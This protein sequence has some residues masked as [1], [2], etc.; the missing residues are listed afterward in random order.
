MTNS[1][2][3]IHMLAV[4]L[5]VTGCSYVPEW[6]G[7]RKD[8][9]PALPGERLSV[10]P[11]ESSIE[12]DATLKDVPVTLPSP[13]MNES[14][15]QHGGYLT[16]ASSNLVLAGD[17][18]HEERAEAGEGE[19]FEHSLIPRPI[20]AQDMVFAMDAEGK[21]SAHDVHDISVVRWQSD[22]VSE[23]DEPQIIGGGL[24]FD[25]GRLYAVSGRG[26]V[27]AIDG[28]TGKQ[29]WR[30]ATNIPFRSAPRVDGDM[31]YAVSIDS[32]VY[33]FNAGSGDIVWSQRGIRE[34]AELLNSVTPAV[35]GGI[36][37]VPFP[38]GEIYA[39]SSSDG[40][41]IWSD[42]LATA[43]HRWA[44]SVFAGIGGDPVVDG[45]V[46][47]AVSSSGTFSVFSVISGQ[48]LWEYPASSL[49]TPWITG[50]YAYLLTSENVLVSFH[51]YSG[52]VRWATALPSF[53]KAKSK[54]GAIVWSG[55]V[56]AGG[57][58]LLASSNGELYEIN[59]TDGVLYRKHEIDDDVFTAPVVADGK[60]FLVDK[61]A[62]LIALK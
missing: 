21:I 30:R 20:V 39:L 50:D 47:F 27:V 10:L 46:V 16:A 55:P 29:L 5:V 60:V 56:M 59:A 3:R 2:I 32:Q 12:P 23:E 51:K 17:L 37:I 61:D 41:E 26:L 57:R 22:G 43:S 15:P 8:T 40:R 28:S 9:A 38:S 11:P 49:N 58:L 45:D 54:K 4:L 14:W 48:K 24:A 35:S 52:K 36:V 34:T 44:S 19:H 62:N 31:L 6:M 25:S 33:A 7:G 53:T 1:N 18:D 13:Q 42:S